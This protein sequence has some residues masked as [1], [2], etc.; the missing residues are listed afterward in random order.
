MHFPPPFTPKKVGSCSEP[1]TF[2]DF[3]LVYYVLGLRTLRLRQD[4]VFL[5]GV[6]LPQSKDKMYLFI[7]QI[8]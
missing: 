2:L 6:H 4:R 5:D 1:S 3:L 7:L 8:F